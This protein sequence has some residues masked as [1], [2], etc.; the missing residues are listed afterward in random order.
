MIDKQRTFINS[1]IQNHLLYVIRSI[2]NFASVSIHH[3]NKMIKRR[4]EE[5]NS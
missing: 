4:E 1:G 2:K 3:N 5:I